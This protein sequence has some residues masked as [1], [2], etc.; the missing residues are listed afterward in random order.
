MDNLLTI[1]GKNPTRQADQSQG[2]RDRI[3][4]KTPV[5]RHT[6]IRLTNGCAGEMPARLGFGTQR[7]SFVCLCVPG[8]IS[9][10][11]GR[12]GR[13]G[14]VAHQCATSPRG[15]GP[16]EMRGR[17]LGRPA[18]SQRIVSKVETL[19]TSTDL[20]IRAI[21]KKILGRAGRSIVGEITKRARATQSQAL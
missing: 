21:Q 8:G 20:S 10:S 3:G 5:S 15:C 1:I 11:S 12:H 9:V 13:A 19:A 2:G 14:V 4:R 16:S 6:P 17:H 18:T 7:S